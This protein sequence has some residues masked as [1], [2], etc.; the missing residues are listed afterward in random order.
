MV[1][2]RGGTAGGTVDGSAR[3]SSA[4]SLRR[5]APRPSPRLDPARGN[6]ALA[7]LRAAA[8]AAD[9]PAIRERLSAVADDRERSWLVANVVDVD[10][11]E[12]WMPAVVAAEPDSGLAQLVAGARQVTWAWE[13]RTGLRAQHVSREQFQVFHERLEVAEDLLYR[14]AELEPAWASP[15]YFLQMSGRGLQVGPDLARLRFEAT[16]RRSPLHLGAH[17]QQLQQVCRKWGGSHEEMHAF[18][19]E[20]M[21]AA[22]EGSDLGVLVAVAHLEHWGDLDRGDDTAY[23]LR[24]QVEKE[25]HEAADRSYRNA[26]YQ[27]ALDPV[28]TFNAFA[29]AFALAGEKK[30]AAEAFA[31]TGGL[32]TEFPWQYLNGNDPVAAY[33]SLRSR[34]GR[35]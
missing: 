22:P 33:R 21:L 14:A 10:G 35:P 18:A 30:A 3:R 6:P 15:W 34:A 4:F 24:L 23:M 16:V 32:V 7:D 28:G 31:A 8:A 29:M 20:S 17:Q 11:W 19:R 1:A 13:A 5:W 9:W 25:L 2:V 27:G 12:R 26:A